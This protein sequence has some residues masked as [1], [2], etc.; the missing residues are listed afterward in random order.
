M[1]KIRLQRP[2]AD[3]SA[4]LLGR[5]A[6]GPCGLTGPKCSLLL[7]LLHSAASRVVTR[8]QSDELMGRI[9]SDARLVGRPSTEKIDSQEKN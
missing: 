7:G 8:L 3:F 4:R 5:S 1:K 2:L 6:T 9:L